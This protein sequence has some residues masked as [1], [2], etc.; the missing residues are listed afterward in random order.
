MKSDYENNHDM[1]YG[2]LMNV[3]NSV[4]YGLYAVVLSTVAGDG[5]DFDYCLFLGFVGL[6]NIVMLAPVMVFIH[7]M[8]WQEFVMPD[9]QELAS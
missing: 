7:L 1:L 2:D 6:I 3:L 5:D 4:C 8:G 9:V